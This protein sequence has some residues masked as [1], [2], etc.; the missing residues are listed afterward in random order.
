MSDSI[1]LAGY[2]VTAPM[3]P[4]LL[5]DLGLLPA[6]IK[7]LLIRKNTS[8]IIP[9]Q[10]QQVQFQKSFFNFHSLLTEDD[11]SSWL[12]VN[13][14]SESEMTLH[15]YRSLQQEILKNEMFSNKVES[16]FLEHKSDLDLYSYSLI[17]SNSRSKISEIY[18]QLAEEEDTFAS[19]SHQFSEGPESLTNGYIAPK[20]LSKVHPEIAE[21]LR[22]SN[23]GQLWPP[24]LVNQSWLLIRLE[25]L[26]PSS[27]D[28]KTSSSILSILFNSW[29]DEQ[30]A[31]ELSK[32]RSPAESLP[33][34]I[35]D[36]KQLLDSQFSASN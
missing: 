26:I 1:S 18:V 12:S 32:F 19:L 36:Y 20:P 35:I 23:P 22:I 7:R 4:S 3:L 17:Q 30:L 15:L 29:L 33:L 16:Y 5:L 34:D 25:K 11:L 6:F 10:E 28:S 13:D 8:H 21:R 9:T 14:L 24:F 27:L 2:E 31:E